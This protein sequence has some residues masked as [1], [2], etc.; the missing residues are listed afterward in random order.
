M[1]EESKLRQIAKECEEDNEH[2]ELELRRLQAAV[3]QE[4]KNTTI[5]RQHELRQL[6]LQLK[7]LDDTLHGLKLQHE[8]LYKQHQQSQLLLVQAQVSEPEDSGHRGFAG[9]PSP[10]GDVM[11]ALAMNGMEKQYSD[12]NGPREVLRNSLN[13]LDLKMLDSNMQELLGQTET[14]GELADDGDVI[15]AMNY[16]SQ[17]RDLNKTNVSQTGLPLSRSN[18]I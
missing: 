13:N 11:G 1:E 10:A 7:G 16:L 17:L 9:T 14:T 15:E 4:K 18:D 5:K 3:E 8:S 6:R 12:R 2:L